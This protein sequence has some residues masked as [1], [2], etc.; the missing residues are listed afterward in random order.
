[1]GM[2]R[3]KKIFGRMV[4]RGMVIRCQRGAPIEAGSEIGNQWGSTLQLA[5]DLL[6]RMG[7]QE[8]YRSKL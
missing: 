7:I 3:V 4:K 8:V 5:E 2:C 1:M 6:L